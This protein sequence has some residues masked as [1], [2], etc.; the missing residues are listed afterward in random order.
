M[1]PINEDKQ[2][3]Y[4]HDSQNEDGISLT[5]PM[6]R[7]LSSKPQGCKGFRKPSKPCCVG[8]NGIALTE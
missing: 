1:K 5:L 4:T 2:Q 6:L 3:W 7:L 8:I